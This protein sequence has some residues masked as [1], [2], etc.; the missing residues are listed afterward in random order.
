M[1]G[2]SISYYTVFFITPF[3][4]NVF[5]AGVVINFKKK[6]LHQILLVAVTEGSLAM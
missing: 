1:R 5:L 6:A 3:F 2:I 4:V